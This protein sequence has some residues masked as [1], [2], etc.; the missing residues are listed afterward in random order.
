[1]ARKR[2]VVADHP[3]SLILSPSDFYLFGYL[4]GLFRGEIFETGEQLLSAL[5]GIFQSLDKRT[6]TNVFLEWMTRLERCIETNGDYV[7]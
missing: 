3:Y 4:K 6:L 7:G 5:E 1:M 2:M